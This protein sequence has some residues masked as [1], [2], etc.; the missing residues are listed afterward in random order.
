[1]SPFTLTDE[2]SLEEERQYR[3]RKERYLHLQLVADAFRDMGDRYEEEQEVASWKSPPTQQGRWHSATTVTE[4]S[5]QGAQPITV[6]G[7][8]TLHPVPALTVPKSITPTAVPLP[9]MPGP[10][11][12][13]QLAQP[14]G[15]AHDGVAEF[16]KDMD[17][18]KLKV[19]G[20]ELQLSTLLRMV[21]GLQDR[22]DVH[23]GDV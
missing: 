17:F 3:I 19:M 2:M 11:T 6:P 23:F 9:I 5:A 14:H 10:S 22:M 4:D 18:L 16:R 8:S 21:K 13:P 20:L 15:Q 12:G 7:P 1:M